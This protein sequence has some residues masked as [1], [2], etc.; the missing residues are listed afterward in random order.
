LTKIN[1]TIC[2]SIDYSYHSEYKMYS[3][4]LLSEC[5][6]NKLVSLVMVTQIKK[7]GLFEVTFN[8]IYPE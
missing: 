8:L 4:T 1:N 7:C 3:Q 2:S 5:L 6:I